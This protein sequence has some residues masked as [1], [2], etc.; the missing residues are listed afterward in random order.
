MPFAYGILQL[1]LVVGLQQLFKINILIGAW[2]STSYKL[3]S[4]DDFEHQWL[5]VISKYDM[6]MNKHVNGLYQIKH[7][8]APC[9]LRGY[10]FG[11]MT[12][13]GRSESINAFIKRFVTAHISLVEFAKQVS[14]Y[15]LKCL[16][17]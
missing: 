14:N 13:T 17:F 10:F 16:Y 4:C 12:T 7:F 9:Y 1:S 8:W 2:I 6:V 5:Q 11:G 3:D 15:P